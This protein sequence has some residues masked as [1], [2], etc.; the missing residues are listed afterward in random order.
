ME[1]V[2]VA[3]KYPLVYRKMEAYAR[4]MIDELPDQVKEITGL[5]NYMDYI[6]SHPYRI[7]EYFDEMGLILQVG[8]TKANKWDYEIY[9]Q[10]IYANNFDSRLESESDG[11]LTMFKLLEKKLKEK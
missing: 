2:E 11:V 5:R 8:Y 1:P 3:E 10:K 9:N 6:M 7:I 4:D